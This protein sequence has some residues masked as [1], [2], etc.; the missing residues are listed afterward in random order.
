MVPTITFHDLLAV[1]TAGVVV[2]M[3]AAAFITYKSRKFFLKRHA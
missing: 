1:F 3:I 2:G